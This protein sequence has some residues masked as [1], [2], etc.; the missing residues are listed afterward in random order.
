MHQ[1]GT[2]FLHKFS[3]ILFSM[4]CLAL[5]IVKT[6]LQAMGRCMGVLVIRMSKANLYEKESI[7]L[8]FLQR[9][10]TIKFL[11][12]TKTRGKVLTSDLW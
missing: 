12:Q 9:S 8:V 3:G 4:T 11:A 10:P 5:K 6:R 2:T 7:I 1:I